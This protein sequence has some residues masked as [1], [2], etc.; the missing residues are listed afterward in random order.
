MR[1]RGLVLLMLSALAA[2]ALVACTSASA[3]TDERTIVF[4]FSRFE[5]SVVTVAVGVPVHLTLRNDDPIEHEWIAGTE[6][7][8]ERHRSGT[9]PYHDQVPTEVSV[10][11]LAS[12]KTIVRFDEAGDYPFVCHLPGHEAYGMRGILRVVESKSGS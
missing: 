5:Q 9:E 6:E 10:P 3:S 7:V 2:G 12:R 1:R 4:R 11:A 8:H